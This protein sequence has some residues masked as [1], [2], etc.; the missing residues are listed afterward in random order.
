M[1]ADKQP[2]KHSFGGGK[3]HILWGPP[4]EDGVSNDT[5]HSHSSADT[6]PLG[7]VG[8]QKLVSAVGVSAKFN[9]FLVNATATEDFA[10][11]KLP[12]GDSSDIPHFVVD[13]SSSRSASV[14]GNLSGQGPQR[15]G[16]HIL[17]P[18]DTMSELSEGAQSG[19]AKP[20]TLT[21]SSGQ[22]V[23]VVGRSVGSQ[24]HGVGK[25]RPCMF[26]HTVVGCSNGAACTF[27]HLNHRRTKVT[28]PCKAKRDKFKA[29]V[30]QQARQTNADAA[31]PMAASPDTTFDGVGAAASPEWGS[32]QRDREDFAD[33]AMEH[34]Y[35]EA[36]K[37]KGAAILRL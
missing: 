7:K 4:L 10:A 27:C 20:V 16:D 37:A 11:R 6:A 24:N 8:S 13:G 35:A 31:A 28:R 15:D 32:D 22:A 21:A 29:L 17:F 1:E 14:S 36:R 18:E 34:E 3:L 33:S 26:V 23:R 30:E 12:N 5:C 19:D 25:C 2:A 9:A